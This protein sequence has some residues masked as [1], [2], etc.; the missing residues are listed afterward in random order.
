MSS[1]IQ[2][3]DIVSAGS[4]NYRVFTFSWELIDICQ[5][6]CS[7][8]SAMHFNISMFKEHPEWR[9]AW[10]HV[11]KMLS[12]KTIKSPFAIEILGGEPTLHPDIHDIVKGACAIENN[13]RVEL[14]TNFAKSLSFFEEFDIKENKKLSIEISYHPEYCTDKWIQKIIDFSVC[15]HLNI[16]PNINLPDEKKWW[17]QTKELLDTLKD[18]NINIGL[19]FLQEVPSGPQGSWKPEYTDEF[20]KYFHDYFALDETA[21]TDTD[22]FQHIDNA[23]EKNIK[24]DPGVADGS[25]MKEVEYKTRDGETHLLSEVEINRYD[26]RQFKGWK[27]TP[28]M[29]IINMAGTVSNHCTGEELPVYKVNERNLTACREC[30]LD[31]CNCD[32]KFLY[33][34]ERV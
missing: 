10:R 5:Y 1:I 23:S 21:V 28:L 18:N 33:A 22:K 9:D 25:M 11:L 15:K 29:Y 6:N 32:T 30:P 12:L 16:S 26:L 4:E 3:D 13:R 8:C 24:S 27:C 20:W 19:N 14:V 17:P 7:Y 34:K 2:M 31:R